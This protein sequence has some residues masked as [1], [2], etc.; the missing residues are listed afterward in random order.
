MQGRYKPSIRKNC[1]ICKARYACDALFLKLGVNTQMFVVTFFLHLQV[2]DIL[3]NW[4]PFW[5]YM[6]L[7]FNFSYIFFKYLYVYTKE[8]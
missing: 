2:K 1:N 6:L 7:Y 3:Q 4:S 8:L 5:K